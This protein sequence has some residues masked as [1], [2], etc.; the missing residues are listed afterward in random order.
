MCAIYKLYIRYRPTPA[1]QDYYHWTKC[2]DLL[3]QDVRLTLK[4]RDGLY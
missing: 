2:L 4:A 3:T 1:M